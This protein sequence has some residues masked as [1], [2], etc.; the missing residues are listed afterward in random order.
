MLREAKKEALASRLG[1][2]RF[3][4][5]S[6]ERQD[7]QSEFSLTTDELLRALVSYIQ[8]L[9][10]VP[11]SDF[12]VGVAGLNEAGEVFLGVNLE[13]QEASFAQTVHA[14]QFV[15]SWSRARSSSPLTTLAV[16][17]PPCGHCRQF[18]REF[19]HEGEL[20]VLIADEPPMKAE[21]LLPRAF[22]PAD[23]KV[24]ESFY[25]EPLNLDPKYSLETAARR[26]AKLSYVPYSRNMAGVA[27]R[28][29]SGIIFAGSSIENAAYNPAL[30]PLQAALI[31]FTA[32][33]CWSEGIA[34]I[35]LCQE[36]SCSIDYDPQSRDLAYSLGVKGQS[37]R[38]IVF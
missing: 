27:L 37:F 22:G 18:V 3:Y 23:L 35:V 25:S 15:I 21:I 30:P 12:R 11:V 29:K 7:L 1:S 10:I 6:Q 33:S 5:S 19:D 28:C 13:F 38:T 36:E 14:E 8:G 4:L 17:A 26:A 31:A 2:R 32:G 16:S 24:T 34:E 9:A 20:S